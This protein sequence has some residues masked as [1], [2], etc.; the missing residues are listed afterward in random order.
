[1]CDPDSVDVLFDRLPPRDWSKAIK[2][3]ISRMA[4]RFHGPD[5]NRACLE[6]ILDHHWGRLNTLGPRECGDLRRDLLKIEDGSD[7]SWI[8]ERLAKPRHCDPK[9]F[10]EL[11][12]TPAMKERM[13]RHSLGAL[14]PVPSARRAAERVIRPK[15]PSP[16][17]RS[18]QEQHEEWLASLTPA[19]RKK[20]LSLVITREQLYAEVWAEP[21]TKVAERYGVSDVAIA[22]WCRRM[23]VPRP[24]RGYWA[25]KAA[26][27]WVKEVLLPPSR[28]RDD[29]VSFIDPNRPRGDQSR[30]QRSRASNCLRSRFRFP[31]YH[32]SS[33]RLSPRRAARSREHHGSGEGRGLLTTRGAGCLD[34]RTCRPSVQR[35]LRIANAIIQALERPGFAV[36]VAAPLDS[37]GTQNTFRT[38]AVIRDVRIQFSIAEAVEKVERPPS[39]EE[40]AK[41]RRNPW[42]IRGPFFE[43][44]P[45]GSLS[46]LIE[47]DWGRERHRRT[48]SDG[49]QQRLEDHLYSFIR[50]LLISAD[51][52][53]RRKP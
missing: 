16:K 38:F 22:K 42:H 6:R 32:A 7:F 2:R 19:N 23:N 13:T 37:Q 14:L 11:V 46:L 35:A 47:G 51:A 10:S 4:W 43:Y 20:F 33:T 34:L 30:R 24:G 27:R 18:E 15:Q 3:N 8:L 1:M 21:A 52:L 44:R 49:Q 40:R 39:D 36:E 50:G 28:A 5:A 48:W 9:I 29:G 17:V 53:K 26:G 45:T 41:M 25:R 31:S 12:R